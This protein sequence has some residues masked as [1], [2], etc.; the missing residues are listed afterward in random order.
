MFKQAAILT[1]CTSLVFSTGCASN[2]VQAQPAPQTEQT[3]ENKDDTVTSN[4]KQEPT[5]SDKIIG[6]TAG[7]IVAVGVV[8]LMA[9]AASAS[10]YK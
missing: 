5:L 1:M 3:Q 8:A 10:N 2:S 7:A 6:Y 4:N 9:A